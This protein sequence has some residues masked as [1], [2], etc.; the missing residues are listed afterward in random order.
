MITTISY[1][2][3]PSPDHFPDDA[4]GRKSVLVLFV[5]SPIFLSLGLLFFDRWNPT[6]QYSTIFLYFWMVLHDWIH[7]D[8]FACCPVMLSTTF[9]FYD[10]GNRYCHAVVISF[11]AVI[12]RWLSWPLFF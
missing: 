2:G 5:L 1:L 9:C 11:V 8:A 12:L 7:D 6:V 3:R 4:P 10:P